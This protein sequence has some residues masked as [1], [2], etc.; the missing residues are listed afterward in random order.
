MT[1]VTPF[2]LAYLYKDLHSAL[3]S[4][5]TQRA[6]RSLLPLTSQNSRESMPCPQGVWWCF[7]HNNP[8]DFRPQLSDEI[9]YLVYQLE[10]GGQG[11]PHLQ[12]VVQ[13]K[14]R[15]T[16]LKRVKEIMNVD[17]A[18]LMKSTDPIKSVTLVNID[19][20]IFSY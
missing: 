7:T 19:Y 10:V 2:H 16:T 3:V 12:G 8:G 1:R 15:N 4:S 9:Q 14:S 20:R 17:Q 18:E 5:I 11:T 6:Y 13:F